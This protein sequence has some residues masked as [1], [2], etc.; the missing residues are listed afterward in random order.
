[1]LRIHRG[2]DGQWRSTILADL[3]GAPE[4]I[5]AEA[6]G[7]WLVAVPKG[8]VR[9]NDSGRVEEVWSER[10]LG[11]LYPTSGVRLTDGTTFFGMRHFVLR[12]RPKASS[13]DVDV[14]VP[15]GCSI[16]RCACSE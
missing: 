13:Y 16:T 9:L 15:P 10:Y 11:T 6:P 14:L 3:P 12:L 2:D 1:V 4:A 8:V 7:R 5:A